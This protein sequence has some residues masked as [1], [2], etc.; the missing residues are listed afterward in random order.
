MIGAGEGRAIALL[1]GAE[2]IAAMRAF[3]E[4][5]PDFIVAVAHHQDRHRPDGFGHIIVFIGDLAGMTDIDPCAIPDF[6]QLFLENVLVIIKAAVDAGR[7]DEG[8][9]IDG[10][11]LLRHHGT[12]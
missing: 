5:E 3:V 12:E 11:A 10:R 8:F 4:Q 9:I 2:L 6:F 7:F 1:I